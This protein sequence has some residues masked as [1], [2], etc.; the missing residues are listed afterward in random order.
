MI[1]VVKEILYKK[2][3]SEGNKET[4]G[5]NSSILPTWLKIIGLV[6]VILYIFFITFLVF[7]NFSSIIFG[8]YAQT[9]LIVV[10]LAGSPLYIS[11]IANSLVLFFFKKKHPIISFLILELISIIIYFGLVYVSYLIKKEMDWF[12]FVMIGLFTVTL[13]VNMILYPILVFPRKPQD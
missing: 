11:W 1:N 8:D 13:L 12:I 10:F 4:K 7:P 6:S 9:I 3:S 2:G 5:F